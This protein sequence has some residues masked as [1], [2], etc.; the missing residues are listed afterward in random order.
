MNISIWGA[1]YCHISTYCTSSRVRRGYFPFVVE[2]TSE[3]EGHH[4][5]DSRAD[6]DF[7]VC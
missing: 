3:R 1:N 4:G 6:P 2:L 5:A 7:D